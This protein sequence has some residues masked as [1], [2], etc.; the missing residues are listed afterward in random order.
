MRF[1]VNR[2]NWLAE[3]TTTPAD[4]RAKVSPRQLRSWIQDFDYGGEYDAADVR[5]QIDGS[6][7]VGVPAFMLWDPA[8]RYTP[9]ALARG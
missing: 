4:V 6:A 5:A 3:A 7:E 8:N 9:A 2:A 1:A